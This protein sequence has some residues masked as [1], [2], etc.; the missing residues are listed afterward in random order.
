VVVASVEKVCYSGDSVPLGGDSDYEYESEEED[1]KS[2]PVGTAREE[3]PADDDD[4]EAVR[5]RALM[6]RMK[7][8][9]AAATAAMVP[10]FPATAVLRPP[11]ATEPTVPPPEPETA[12]VEPAPARPKTVAERLSALERIAKR[13]EGLA[14]P[15]METDP[16]AVIS[17]ISVIA[18]QVK[19]RQG[20][21]ERLQRQLA[22]IKGRATGN[23]M[24]S[25]Q[26]EMTRLD[27]EAA[28]RRNAA[29]DKNVKEK[30]RQL[31][32]LQRSLDTAS[33]KAKET[34]TDLVKQLM[35]GV[36]QELRDRLESGGTFSGEEVS[37]ELAQL[38]KNQAEQTFAA[39]IETG[40]I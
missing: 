2:A 4:E 31:K 27:V 18:A 17:G 30:A 7:K 29:L 5:K 33:A 21:V 3:P 9:G 34:A 19:A 16:N 28:R 35:N 22:E 37:A 39:I 10:A 32:E 26:I 14:Q 40:L 23:Q 20:Q 36:F 11:M 24:Q 25:R 12:P 38:L 13:I 15:S 6:S 1:A 8:I